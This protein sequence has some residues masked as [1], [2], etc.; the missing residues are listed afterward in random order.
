MTGCTA[1]LWSAS[2]PF[3]LHPSI[4]AAFAS[5]VREEGWVQM[6]RHCSRALLLALSALALGLSSSAQSQSPP[7]PLVDRVGFPDDYQTTF[8]PLYAFDRPDTRQVRVVYGNHVAT[9]VPKGAPYPYGSVLVMETYG[10]R[11][12]AATLTPVLDANGRYMRGNLAGIF[13]MRKERGYGVEYEHNRTGE[14][15]YVAYR[16]D[17]TFLT[18]PRDSWSCANCH[19]QGTAA[20]D[21]V[22][23]RNLIEEGTASTGALPDGVLQVYSFL[24]ATI[25]VRA[26][27]FVTWL[28]D[29]E[30]D[31]RIAV[32]GTQP[33]E[34]PLM[35][36]GNSYR[37]RFNSTGE[38]DVACRIHPTMRGRVIVDP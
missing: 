13:V 9:S 10:A 36:S 15:E 6:I 32:L 34:G 28:N 3:Q 21:W 22:F 12:S 27:S 7:A 37:I 2:K 38:Y 29:D 30:V 1:A 24:P 11:L 18:P 14:W 33:V 20:R 23:R 19:L 25:R 31:H 8:V 26:G 16:A 4:G 5:C 35:T 17:R